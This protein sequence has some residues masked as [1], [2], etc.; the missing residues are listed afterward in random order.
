MVWVN[1][2]F[3]FVRQIFHRYCISSSFSSEESFTLFPPIVFDTWLPLLLS[4]NILS[5]LYLE[6]KYAGKIIWHRE[7]FTVT[8]KLSLELSSVRTRLER[9]GWRT[10]RACFLFAFNIQFVV[11]EVPGEFKGASSPFR[12]Q[13]CS[14]ALGAGWEVEGWVGVLTNAK[15]TKNPGLGVFSP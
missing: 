6:Y 1:I 11:C 10:E 3:L 8:L 9:C 4:V 7:E 13:L 15:W 12:T 14:Q 5:C 2:A